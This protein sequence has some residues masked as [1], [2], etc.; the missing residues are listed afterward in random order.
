M[1]TVNDFIKELQALKPSVRELPVTV[2]ARNGLEFEAKA[3]IQ[4]EYPCI[5]GHDA[6]KAVVIT[7]D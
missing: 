5:S 3:K 6:P 2:I 7:W 4:L 1:K